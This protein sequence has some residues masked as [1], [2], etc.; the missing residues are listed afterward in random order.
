MTKLQV[1][2]QGLGSKS[3]VLSVALP[4]GP[5][6]ALSPDPCFVESDPL[7]GAEAAWGTRV[8]SAS[9]SAHHQVPGAHPFTHSLTHG[10][11]KGQGSLACYSPWGHKELDTS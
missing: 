10:D 6:L 3:S 11:S 5:P 8:H 2:D 9:D 7:G 1:N 4:A